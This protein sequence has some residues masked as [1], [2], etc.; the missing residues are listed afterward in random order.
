VRRFVN[1]AALVLFLT[2]GLFLTADVI[3]AGNELMPVTTTSDEARN[4][5]H[6]GWKFIDTGQSEKSRPLFEKAL[7]LDPDFALAHVGLAFS[8]PTFKDMFASAQR[9]TELA[10][11]GQFTDA[12]KLFIE[13]AWAALNADTET[14]IGN[15][16]KIAEMFPRDPRSQYNMGNC[17]LFGQSDPAGSIPYLEAAVAIDPSF[18]PVHN[19]LGWGYRQLGEFDKAEQSYRRY[20]ELTPENPA[21]HDAYAAL[22]LKLGRFDEST[23]SYRT[24]LRYDPAY[25]SSHQGICT[26]LMLDGKHDEA[27]KHIKLLYEKAPND[28]IRSG[29]HFATAVIYTDEGKLDMALE[30]LKKNFALSEKLEDALAMQLDLSNMARVLTEMGRYDEAAAKYKK[31]LEIAMASDQADQR[32]EATK[33]VHLYSVGNIALHKGDIDTAK[34][35]AAE[36]ASKAEAFGNPFIVKLAHQL[37]GMIALETKDYQRA[38]DEFMLAN[39]GDAYN[40]YRMALAFEGMGNGEK[41]VEMLTHVVE[42]RGVLNLNYAFVRHMAEAKLN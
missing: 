22:L 10:K 17:V 28:G 30:E 27:R 41:A 6:E 5:Y 23:T 12:E 25:M 42:Y 11:T 26:S 31:S 33:I 32:K 14:W 16:R 36:L 37:A 34:E 8:Q 38:I 13:A 15:T 19:S 20:I 2:A 4:L 1:A 24:A 9:A 29:I 3:A 7:S 18:T 40:M 21:A 35:T 39:N